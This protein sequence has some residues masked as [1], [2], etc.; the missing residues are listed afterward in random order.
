M[1]TKGEKGYSLVELLLA[2]AITALIAGVLVTSIYQFTVVSSHGTARLVALDE[3][4]IAARWVIRDSQSA[5]QAATPVACGINCTSVDLTVPDPSGTVTYTAPVPALGEVFGTLTY[6]TGTIT[7]SMNGT[8]LQRSVNG[9]LAQTIA[10][11][12]DV[13]FTSLVEPGSCTPQPCEPTRDKNFVTM[14]ITAPVE[15]GDDIVEEIH[16][17]LR[18]TGE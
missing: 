18:S 15:H 11:D 3:V 16:M 8:D 17:F 1:I 7:Y 5:I 10:H 2:S 4:Q 6:T 9:G 13:T 12:V 14:D